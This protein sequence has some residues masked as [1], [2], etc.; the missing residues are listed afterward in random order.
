MRAADARRSAS[1]ISSSS[2]SESLTLFPSGRLADRL[3][4]EDFCAADVLADL[5]AGFVVFEFVDQRVADVQ[6]ADAWRSLR[7]AAG[8]SFR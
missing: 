8:S 4:D 3:D 1:I 6:L 2:I 7:R 5:D